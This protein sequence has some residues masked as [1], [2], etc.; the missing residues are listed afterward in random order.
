MKTQLLWCGLSGERL[1]WSGSV[2]DARRSLVGLLRLRRH[3]WYN[4]GLRG[5][6]GVLNPGLIVLSL[7]LFGELLRLRVLLLLSAA[8]VG[9]LLL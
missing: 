2:L 3:T 6:G 1:R 7:L 5:A 8:R 4:S 9:L